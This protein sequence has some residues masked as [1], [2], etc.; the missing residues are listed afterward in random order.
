[1]VLSGG[2][3]LGVEGQLTERKQ[4]GRNALI[5]FGGGH[6]MQLL[7]GDHGEKIAADAPQAK[8][9]FVIVRIGQTVWLSIIHIILP[10]HSR[11][12]RLVKGQ[13]ARGR[14]RRKILAQRHPTAALDARRH[15]FFHPYDNR[16]TQQEANEDGEIAAG[17]EQGVADPHRLASCS[18]G[19][20]HMAAKIN[21][22]MAAIF[23]A[24][25][26]M[27]MTYRRGRQPHRAPPECRPYQPC[28][29]EQNDGNLRLDEIEKTARLSLFRRNVKFDLLPRKTVSSARRFIEKKER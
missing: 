2:Q 25:Q 21:G 8:P 29:G 5:A 15:L 18:S 16:K 17:G 6:N 26:K 7:C 20:V 11:P 23:T 22:S 27:L 9:G 13:L 10:G 14:E 12:D 19:G 1:M 3:S 28:Q 4:G 24:P